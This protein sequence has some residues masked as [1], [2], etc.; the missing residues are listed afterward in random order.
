MRGVK[1]SVSESGKCNYTVNVTPYTEDS[2]LSPVV[3]QRNTETTLE[4]SQI[5][6]N[7]ATVTLVLFIRGEC[8]DAELWAECN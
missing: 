3:P 1:R 8:E 5:F 2:S 4:W 6:N 7:M